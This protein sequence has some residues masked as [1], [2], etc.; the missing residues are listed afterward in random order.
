MGHWI[1]DAVVL[2]WSE[3]TAKLSEGGVQPGAVINLLLRDAD[4]LRQDHAIRDFYMARREELRCAWTDKRLGDG[5]DVDH[6][7]PFAFWQASPAWNLLPA[8]PSVN[9]AKRDKLPAVAIVKKRE[10]AIVGCWRLVSRQFPQRFLR[11][12]TGLLGAAPGRDWER[13]LMAGFVEAI[14][15]TASMRGA[16]RWEP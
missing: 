14:E 7:I 3:M 10:E 13:P 16:D 1:R 9:N 5:L 6:A 4:P 12:A 2:R 15:Y 8:S 11:D